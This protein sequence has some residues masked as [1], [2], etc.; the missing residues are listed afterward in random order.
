M[1]GREIPEQ[2]MNC[3]IKQQKDKASRGPLFA[4]EKQPVCV[5]VRSG[6]IPCHHNPVFH[7]QGGHGARLQTV[8]NKA[9]QS[10]GIRSLINSA[11]LQHLSDSKC[12]FGPLV[13]AL[14]VLLV[15]SGNVFAA[16]RKPSDCKP[17]LHPLE[18]HQLC[19]RLISCTRTISILPWEL[20]CDHPVLGCTHRV[21]PGRFAG[22]FDLNV[23]ITVQWNFT[24]KQERGFTKGTSS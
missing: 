18:T 9:V 13:A 5:C 10:G 8:P 11:Y 21:T 20:K 24:F 1:V 6:R 2:W 16:R 19:S 23:L 17:N 14:F 7:Q 15:L 22:K 3:L 4:W 12:L